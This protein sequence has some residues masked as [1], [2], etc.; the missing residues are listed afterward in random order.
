MSTPK[1]IIQMLN[2]L[3]PLRHSV[4]MWGAPGVGKSEV[5]GQVGVMLNR[6]VYDLRANLLDPV[7]V[8][9]VPYVQYWNN[10]IQNVLSDAVASKQVS[11]N[12]WMMIE[13]F[14]KHI[15][16]LS[17]TN[18]TKSH[19]AIPG[20]LPKEEDG[21]SILGLDELNTAPP[22]TQNAFLQITIKP[23]RLGEY[24]L[25][26][27][28]SVVAC[29]NRLADRVHAF[30]MSSALSDRFFHIDFDPDLD[31]WVEWAMSNGVVPELIGF[32]RA[33][34]NLLHNFDPSK[35][36]RSF[37]TPRGW[38]MVSDVC[39]TGAIRSL[40]GNI[41]KK[42]TEFDLIS[43]KVGDGPA[44]EFIT[45][46]KTFRKLPDLKEVL[47]HP[48]KADV[49]EDPDMLYAICGALASKASKQTID[50]IV[51]YAERLRKEFSVLLIM[52]SV[53]KDKGVTYTPAF[54]RWASNNAEVI[55]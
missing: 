1:Q 10:F 32:L 8:R 48:D 30:R 25:P 16:I 42:N 9:G 53:R 23:Y 55:I 26:P 13:I 27:F 37:P 21:P 36:E 35:N 7:D 31:D 52:D 49:P 39:K 44:Y 54:T 19:W 4:Y 17:K 40:D 24:E 45:F 6:K 14:L 33:R 5:L 28:C 46:L 50:A 47:R 3:I 51:T 41:D 22:L 15:N 20:F 38:V 11:K 29:G 2:V 34:T 43:G 18:G 12:P